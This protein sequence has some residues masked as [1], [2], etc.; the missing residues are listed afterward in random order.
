MSGNSRLYIY[1]FLYNKKIVE[2]NGDYW[3]CNPKYYKE[4]DVMN[5]MFNNRYMCVSD[6]WSRDRAKIA[7][8]EKMGYSVYVVWES[9]YRQNPQICIENCVNFL[10]S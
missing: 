2:F 4:T 6:V 3:H 1:D 7:F 5:S 9:E 8:A 10:N